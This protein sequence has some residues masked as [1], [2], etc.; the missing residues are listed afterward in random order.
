MATVKGIAR[1]IAATA[2]VKPPQGRI[3]QPPATQNCDGGLMSYVGRTTAQ[4]RRDSKSHFGKARSLS[5]RDSHL[6]QR[7]AHRYRPI[8]LMHSASAGR[9]AVLPIMA[10]PVL[11]AQNSG[12]SG[13]SSSVTIELC[14]PPTTFHPHPQTIRF[15]A[16]GPSADGSDVTTMEPGRP[17]R[18]SVIY[19]ALPC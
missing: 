13:G 14:R 1:G 9:G 4:M 5:S 17:R 15:E 11:L 12:S 18:P 3:S 2:W 8:R 19:L 10:A 6:L 7:M 16:S